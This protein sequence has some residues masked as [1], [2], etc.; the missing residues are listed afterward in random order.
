[1]LGCCCKKCSDILADTYENITKVRPIDPAGEGV[2]P[3]ARG[4]YRFSASGCELLSSVAAPNGCG[5]TGEAVCYTHGYDR[6]ALSFLG[7]ITGVDACAGAEGELVSSII[8]N[9]FRKT[10]AKT[11]FHRASPHC[12]MG[13][14]N[15]A[16]EAFWPGRFG[17]VDSGG[18][19]CNT[20]GQDQSKYTAIEDTETVTY[21]RLLWITSGSVFGPS[22]ENYSNNSRAQT[23]SVDDS[24]NLTRTG[25]MASSSGTLGFSG[26]VVDESASS[27]YED[28][29]TGVPTV[30]P[31]WH[32]IPSYLKGLCGIITFRY[33]ENGGDPV[34]DWVEIS[35]TAAELTN[36]KIQAVPAA[37]SDPGGDPA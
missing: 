17:F 16:S 15:V 20:G 27:R 3:Y 11:T 32:E 7:K 33:L 30:K 12:G 1:M 35:G 14:K 31:P 21:D 18:E 13:F 2:A 4:W 5:H 23:C 26:G 24:G 19:C 25:F 8:D 36:L 28:N 6:V 10:G 37:S 34:D 29:C 9:C 22:V